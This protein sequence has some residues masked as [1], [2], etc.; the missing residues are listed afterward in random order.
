MRRVAEIRH[1]LAEQKAARES[2]NVLALPAHAN[3]A[4]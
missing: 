2:A 4:A 3:R 1:M